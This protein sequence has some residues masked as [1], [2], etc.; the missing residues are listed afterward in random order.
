LI[1][2]I[3]IRVKYFEHAALLL[4]TIFTVVATLDYLLRYAR[5]NANLG[6][7]IT[8]IGF[9]IFLLGVL[10]AFSNSQIISRNV[11]GLNLGKEQDNN[12]NIVLQKDILQPMGGYLVRYASNEVRGRE[13]F[14]KVDFMKES[15]FA[16]GKV[17]F[18]VYPSV[19]HNSR[20]GNV[21]NPDTR[22]FL[23][24]DIYTYISFAESADPKAKDG[25]SLSGVKEARV[26]D[27]IVFARSFIILDSIIA[28]MKDEKGENASIT[29]RFRI[30]SMEHGELRTQMRYIIT[31]GILKREDGIVEPLNL[32]LS[33]EGV[34][35]KSDAIKVGL[36]EKKLD[37][38]VIKAIVFPWMNVLW[39]GV[40]IMLCGLSIAVYRRIRGKKTNGTITSNTAGEK[41]VILPG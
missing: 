27:T 8:H 20:M 30:L 29:A 13:T 34:S 25:Y 26:K 7:S 6:A 10:L 21:Y 22:H 38:I 2:A 19:N 18:T 39:G 33:F 12:E 35:D 3:A 37:Y 9:G 4:F 28:D 15:D 41:D 1:V 31:K 24:K 16:S 17:A 32:K 11:S 36:Y 14:Y 23:N 40:V 5:K